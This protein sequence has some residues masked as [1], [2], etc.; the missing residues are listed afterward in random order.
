MSASMQEAEI[1]LNKFMQ[2][3]L[4]FVKRSATKFYTPAPRCQ[5]NPVSLLCMFCTKTCKMLCDAEAAVVTRGTKKSPKNTQMGVVH[6][7]S[8]NFTHEQSQQI[9]QKLLR[10]S[11]A[12][13]ISWW[14]VSS[15]RQELN[16]EF[17]DGLQ[18]PDQAGAGL[19][20]HQHG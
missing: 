2:R 16:R 5:L 11:S 14:E 17:P 10:I 15:G 12:L 7:S 20:R 13:R 1:A 19:L 6:Q 4:L 8:P 18:P 3:T 9:S